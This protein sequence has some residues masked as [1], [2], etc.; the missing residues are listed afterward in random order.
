MQHTI[1]IFALPFP[2]ATLSAH[3]HDTNSCSLSAL[4]FSSV[5]FGNK[6]VMTLFSTIGWT[7]MTLLTSI[8]V[9]LSTLGLVI[10]N[11]DFSLGS[12]PM[13]IKDVST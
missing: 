10:C 7:D 6:I 13:Y 2:M 1:K 12:T 8:V 5:L 3:T 4:N 9:T 11:R